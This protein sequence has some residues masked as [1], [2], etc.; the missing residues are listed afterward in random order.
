MGLWLAQVLHR[1]SDNW[2]KS[3]SDRTGLSEAWI[4]LILSASL[5]KSVGSVGGFFDFS[6][7]SREWDPGVTD[8]IGLILDLAPSIPLYFYFGQ[9]PQTRFFPHVLRTSGFFP[10]PDDDDYIDRLEGEVKFEWWTVTEDHATR[11]SIYAPS[12]RQERLPLPTPPSFPRVDKTS[13]QRPG[14]SMNQFFERRARD[15][16]ATIE[17]ESPSKRQSRL[18]REQN[19]QAQPKCRP[20]TRVFWWEDV[21][22]VRIRTPIGA[23][24]SI[25]SAYSVQQRRYN[26]V[27]N[28]WDIC[29]DFGDDNDDE[30]SDDDRMQGVYDTGGI[31]SWDGPEASP[32]F[33]ASLAESD[34][35][36]ITAFFRFGFTLPESADLPMSQP[37]TVLA[38]D[39]MERLLGLAGAFDAQLVEFFA[40]CASVNAYSR[41]PSQ[42][43]DCLQSSDPLRFPTTLLFHSA[44]L[45]D[46]TSAHT[47]QLYY[48]L[49]DAANNGEPGHKVLLL[50]CPITV[51]EIL[52][53][54]CGPGIAEV[55]RFLLARGSAFQ[56]ALCSNETVPRL[57]NSKR[58]ASSVGVKPL[59]FQPEIWQYHTYTAARNAIFEAPGV[60]RAAMECGGLLARIARP[61][62]NE[63]VILAG[64]VVDVM[65]TG[66]VWDKASGRTYW[67]DTLTASQ[68]EVIC[69]AHLIR[70]C[71]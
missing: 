67:F 1:E 52:R 25:W 20:K 50:R 11:R 51:L 17:K 38:Q 7:S 16:A 45:V 28:E 53:R 2:Q 32:I 68:L 23:D 43:F 58:S 59:G 64:P 3:V 36:Q 39:T 46:N 21:E 33:T 13:G 44:E 62:I 47:K 10:S 56:I 5:A 65:R 55:A 29:S 26:G 22:G 37:D 54:D 61:F 19:A 35:P 49:S 6:N 71:E 15:A 12:P 34:V 8:L 48:I 66:C 14:E 40:Q 70:A 30:D 42:L 63:Q 60:G 31:A 41:I 18:Q 27:Y 57:P 69:G 9:N 24:D 4:A